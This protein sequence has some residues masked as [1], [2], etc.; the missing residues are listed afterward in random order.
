MKGSNKDASQEG[1]LFA[2]QPVFILD[3][4]RIRE[5]GIERQEWES[6][7]VV[8]PWNGPMESRSRYVGGLYF[9][10][11]PGCEE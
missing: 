4:I 5:K 9:D 2:L 8:L 6:V 3:V 11:H 10:G 7:K 1:P